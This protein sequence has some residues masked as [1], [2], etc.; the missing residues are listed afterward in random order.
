MN[1]ASHIVITGFMA[2]GKTA[3][4]GALARLLDCPMADLDEVISRREGRSI[5]AVVEQEGESFFRQREAAALAYV[6]QAQPSVIALGGGAWIMERNRRLISDQD[7]LTVWLDAPF[8]VCWKRI[9]R[10]KKQNRP[11]ARDYDQTRTLYENRRPLYRLAIIHL[12]TNGNRTVDEL[13]AEILSRG[14]R[15]RPALQVN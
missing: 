9:K 4:G 13:A 15:W 6:L 7:C 14:N 10:G 1:D 3:V 11:F 5:S 12:E 2:S 8:E